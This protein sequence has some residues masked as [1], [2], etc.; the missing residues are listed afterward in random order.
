MTRTYTRFPYTTLFRSGI[1][2]VKGQRSKPLDDGDKIAERARFERAVPL[3]RN[4]PLAPGCLQ[5]LGH[6]SMIWC[7][8]PGSNWRPPAYEAGALP[9]ELRRHAMVRPAGLEPAQP[10]GH[11][12]LKPARLPVP[13]RAQKN[14]TPSGI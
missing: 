9:A 8:L 7:R 4:A 12:S 6:L 13:P 2:A 1:A 11:G 5:P 10:C 14:G 3:A